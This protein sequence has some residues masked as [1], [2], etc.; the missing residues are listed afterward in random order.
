MLNLQKEFLDFHD[1]IKL[2]DENKTLKEKREILLDKLSNNICGHSA[3]YTNFNQGSYAMGTGINPVNCDYDIDVGI[4]FEIDKDHYPDPIIVKKWVRDALDGHTK[5]VKI[6]NSCVTVTYQQAEDPLFHVD[7]AIYAGSNHDGKLYIA[8]GKEF[9]EV[10]NK[11]WEVSDPKGLISTIKNKYQNDD[12]KQFRRI[13]RYLKK[14]SAHNFSTN[15]NEKPLGI[16]LTILAF[17]HYSVSKYY[18]WSIQKD[19]YN[20]FEALFNLINIIKNSFTYD[21]VD[22]DSEFSYKISTILPVEPNNNLFE[23]MTDKQMNNFYKK[24]EIFV[25]KLNE[26]KVKEKRVDA[27]SILKD[28]FGDEF[29][30]TVDKSIVGTSESA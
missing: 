7:F 25:E 28:L 17:Y 19:V 13:I 11:K 9:A 30:L 8:K 15:G 4:I 1:D 5:S 24:I 26:V 23:N 14:W 3:K 2:L 27:C 18:D 6:R 29:P 12:A 10:E 21:F 16:A 22:V 20:D